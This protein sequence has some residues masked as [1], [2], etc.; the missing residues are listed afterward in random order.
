MAT[1]WCFQPRKEKTPAF[2]VF[3][4]Q[5]PRVLVRQGVVLGNSGSEPD[6]RDC[7]R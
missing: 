6:L 4:K 2:P 5:E 1:R 7:P 3:V